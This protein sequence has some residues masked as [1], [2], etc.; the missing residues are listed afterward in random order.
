MLRNIIQK[1]K[2]KL[3]LTICLTLGITFLVAV[4]TCQ[5]M[6][7]AGALNMELRKIFDE[8]AVNKNEYPAIIGEEG[9]RKNSG[10][11]FE[12]VCS[13]L[14]KFD[15]TSLKYLEDVD[16]ETKQTSFKLAKTLGH[17][18]FSKRDSYITVSY[19]DELEK[20]I[21]LVDGCFYNESLDFVEGSTDL[22]KKQIE[23]GI[24]EGL[25]PCVLPRAVADSLG[26]VVGE[27]IKYTVWQNKDNKPLILI[28]VGIFQESDAYDTFWHIEP[29]QF[30]SQ[31]FVSREAFSKIIDE[32][33]SDEIFYN[34]YVMLDYEDMNSSNIEE[35]GDSLKTFANVDNTFVDNFGEL[36]DSYLEQKTTI[37]TML[38]VLQLPIIGMVVAFIYM[39]STQIAESEKKEIAMKR[40]RGLTRL[41]IVEGYVLEFGIL[42]V[43]GYI[44][45][46]VLGYALCKLSASTTDF[47]SFDG[48]SAYLYEFTPAMLVYGLVA[49]VAGLIFILIPIVAYSKVSIVEHSKTKQDAVKPLWEKFFLDIILLGISLYLLRNFMVQK[50][51]IRLDVISGNKMDPMIFLDSTLYIV[52][53]GM[54]V[55]RFSHYFTR[56]VYSMG[57]KKWSPAMYASFLQITR[58]FGKQG[59]ISIFMILTVA[60]GLFNANTARTINQNYEDRIQ[61]ENGADVTVKE[62]W[63]MKI[64][65][66]ANGEKDYKYF[67]PDFAR[68]NTLIEKGL[69]TSITKVIK[70]DNAY[71]KKGNESTEVMLLGINTK[72]FGNTANFKD[73]LNKDEH[74]F[75][76]LNE[77]AKNPEGVIISSNY[78]K[79]Y[80]LKLGDKITT[81]RKGDLDS[82]KDIKMEATICAIV[83]DWP[84]FEKYY[85]EENIEKERYLIVANYPMIVSTYHVAPYYVWMKLSDGVTSKQVREALDKAGVDVREYK[86]LSEDITSMKEE[87][88]IIITNGVFT[89]GF[90][91]AIILCALGF[92]IY[93]IASIRQREMLFGIYRAMGLSVK[94]LNKMLTNEHIFSTFLSVISGGIVGMAS[95]L[96]FVGLFG[97]VY[98]PKKHSLDIMLYYHVSDIVKLG[99]VIVIMITVCMLILRK[100]IKSTNITQALKLGEE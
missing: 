53:F 16:V 9:K 79:A 12:E 6:F 72:E 44:V 17:T 22:V 61:Y 90:I 51:T 18:S 24:N 7:K 95:T 29:S 93:W 4:F 88:I 50:D 14:N 91:I 80:E 34:H 26:V 48:N 32:Y 5:P 35:I 47:L 65:E 23:A 81:L 40:S 60:M 31:V 94:Q 46:L 62:Q 76:Y 55:N 98:L 19:I 71:V 10:N 25:V 85:Y 33:G 42:S 89:L 82:S 86:S 45:G 78:A 54:L 92:L 49:I 38:W 52:G 100:I 99:I 36:I 66:N 1:I 73:E 11:S 30:E 68:Y 77:L 13:K 43:F 97:I 59:F 84:D 74:W 67:E 3:W 69:A 27:Q 56:L 63:V 28:I 39:V 41:Q 2:N 21:K 96:L 83:D 58:T 15:E 75:T 70:F 8:Y 64:F 57:R 37:A 87:P 20:H